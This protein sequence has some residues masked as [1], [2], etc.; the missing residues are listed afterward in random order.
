VNDWAL[1]VRLS[2]DTDIW[3]AWLAGCATRSP[4]ERASDPQRACGQL[5]RENVIEV[6]WK[7]AGYYGLD[8]YLLPMLGTPWRP[9]SLAHRG[10]PPPG[11]TG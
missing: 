2:C 7:V 5:T 1:K 4:R 6:A 11:S 9:G 8:R 10:T 3:S